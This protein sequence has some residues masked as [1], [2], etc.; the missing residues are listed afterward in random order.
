MNVVV[1][2]RSA[3]GTLRDFIIATTGLGGVMDG[4]LSGA[5]TPPP[6]R[7]APSVP[8][9]PLKVPS[10]VEI[11]SEPTSRLLA[12]FYSTH[13]GVLDDPTLTEPTL[14]Y[15]DTG[16]ALKAL[17]PNPKKRKGGDLEGKTQKP[18]A[19]PVFTADRSRSAAMK[20]LL[21]NLKLSAEVMGGIV[22]HANASEAV[23][24]N[25]G[26]ELSADATAYAQAN[27][28]FTKIEE[29]LFRCNHLSLEDVIFELGKVH[30]LQKFLG[31]KYRLGVLEVPSLNDG[32]RAHAD[33]RAP[34]EIT[35]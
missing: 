31:L 27:E 13:S 9:R 30:R 26:V 20:L 15:C 7:F 3:G 29:L 8:L 6:P 25:G 32:V 24:P 23:V 28:I 12:G 5:P 14:S 16:P 4:V 21:E 22:A 17:E 2:R 10:E 11:R 18:R 33:R 34:P 1:R 19:S 35:S